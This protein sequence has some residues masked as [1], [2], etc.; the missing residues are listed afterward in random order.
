MDV[1]MLF[2]ECCKVHVLEEGDALAAASYPTSG[3]YIDVR[4][5]HRFALLGIVNAVNSATTVQLQQ[6]VGDDGAPKDI[7][8][9]VYTIPGDGSADGKWFIIEVEVSHLD[10]NNGYTHVSAAVSGVAGGNDTAAL[11]LLE[12]AGEKI[13]VTQADLAS[14]VNVVG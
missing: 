4:G 6:S 2:S 13:P 9:A 5:V 7:T 10:S 3:N 14:A 8:G 11:L 12:F 1:N